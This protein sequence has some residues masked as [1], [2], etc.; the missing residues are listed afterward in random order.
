MSRAFRHARSRM[1]DSRICSGLCS[2]SAAIPS[3]PSSPDTADMIRSRSAAESWATAGEGAASVRSICSGRPAAFPG[4][5]TAMFTEFFRRRMRS[6]SWPQAARPL[7]QSRAVFAANSS[8]VIP[9]RAAS[10]SSIHG[11]KFEGA[12]SGNCSRRL[13]RSP[14]GSIRIEGM[15][16]M[17]AS[18]NSARASPVLPL[19]V[20]PTIIACVVRSF[21]SYRMRLSD[22]A[23][24]P[25]SYSLP[26]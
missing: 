5:Y 9:L 25:V 15:P 2:G 22:A 4:V 21:A 20:M 1:L 16:S 24:A 19:P 23:S 7:F 14:L 12:R 10:D 26:K 6:P 3:R 11:R 18:S 17:A 13:P 8:G